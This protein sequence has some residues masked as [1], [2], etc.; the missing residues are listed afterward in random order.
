MKKLQNMYVALTGEMSLANI[1]DIHESVTSLFPSAAKVSEVFDDSE[2]LEKEIIYE[3]Q[4]PLIQTGATQKEFFEKL[5]QLFEVNKDYNP[6]F[7]NYEK[8][9]IV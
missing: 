1:N 9:A 2:S 6:Y 3:L 4:S 7:T 5:H 8:G